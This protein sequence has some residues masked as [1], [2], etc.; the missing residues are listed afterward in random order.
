MILLLLSI[1]F[2][3]ITVSLFKVFEMRGVNTG[4]AIVFNYL[5]CCLVGILVSGRPE[6]M[7]AVVQSPWILQALILGVLFITIFRFIALTA[8]Q[9][10]VAASMV[11]AKLSVVVPVLIAWAFY[12]ESMGLGKVAGI[13][14]SLLAVFFI[15]RKN[16]QQ[17]VNGTHALTLPAIVFLGSGA[18]DSLLNHLQRTYIPPYSAAQIVTTAFFFAFVGGSIGL[19][20]QFMR[21]RSQPQLK[22]VLWGLGLGVPNYF[23]MYFLV[24]TLGAFDASMILPVN[25]IGIVAASAI[26]AFLFFKERISKL[27]FFGIVLAMAAIILLQWK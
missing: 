17:T 6:E 16:E 2:S 13:A 7:L 9:V 8:Q 22:S 26:T 5:M 18:I 11:A 1:L 12:G 24:M 21:E 15:S 20:I 27:N 14:I 4:H 25:N 23:S 10:S 19:I 3:T